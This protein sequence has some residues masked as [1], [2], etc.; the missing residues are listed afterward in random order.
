MTRGGMP[1]R[2]EHS[3]HHH[4]ERTWKSGHPFVYCT[5]L[6]GKGRKFYEP[7]DDTCRVSC[8]DVSKP[9]VCLNAGFS[10]SSA[11]YYETKDSRGLHL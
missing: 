2:E 5:V 6:C 9:L 4:R 3:I 8:G 10:A 1:A 11:G 7:R